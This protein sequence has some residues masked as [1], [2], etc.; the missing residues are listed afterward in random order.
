[1]NS[2]EQIKSRMPHFF[3]GTSVL[4]CSLHQKSKS[5]MALFENSEYLVID[6]SR[7]DL[8]GVG[9][10]TFMTVLSVGTLNT[11]TNYIDIFRQMHRISSKF[12]LFSCSAPGNT[13]SMSKGYKNL[14]EA[15]FVFNIDFD[16]MFETF[17]FDVNYHTS[18]LFFWGVK[19]SNEV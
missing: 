4:E 8:R 19:S 5:S 12:V 9:D 6:P 16:S 17:K 18:T 10:N 14:T 13:K 1:M 7:K 11:M 2:F 3:I 15:D